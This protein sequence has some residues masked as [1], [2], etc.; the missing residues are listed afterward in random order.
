M[1]ANGKEELLMKVG[2]TVVNEWIK[3]STV[4]IE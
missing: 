3:K 2:E 4:R 1:H